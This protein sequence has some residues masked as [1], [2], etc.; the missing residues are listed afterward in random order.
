MSPTVNGV[1]VTYGTLQYYS[2][3]YSVSVVAPDGHS[4]KN[5]K[6]GLDVLQV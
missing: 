4:V 1:P 3:D 6:T 5:V 2:D